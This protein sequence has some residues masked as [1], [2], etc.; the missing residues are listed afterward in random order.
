[1]TLY[2]MTEAAA[3]LYAMLE[4]E[5]IDEKVVADTL[6]GMGVGDKLEDCCKVIRQFEADAVAYKAEKERF[7]DK[8]KRAENAV[9]RLKNA[10]LGYLLATGK[11]KQKCGV[12]EV[13]RV[14]SKAVNITDENVI[15]VNFRSPQPDK[16]DKAGIR[17]A[18]LTGEQVAG[19]EL[20]INNNLSIK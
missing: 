5:E 8:Q 1:M 15:P 17:K 9:L 3:H 6:E 20:Q 2:E 16:I 11:E 19:A 12:F 18:L 7:A 14:E 10:I 13:K 4:A